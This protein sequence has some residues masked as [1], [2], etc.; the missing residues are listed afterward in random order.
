MEQALEPELE[1]ELQEADPRAQVFKA[2][3]SRLLRDL[4]VTDD[5]YEASLK[6]KEMRRLVEA[7]K[8]PVGEEDAMVLELAEQ[9]AKNSQLLERKLFARELRMESFRAWR[10]ILNTTYAILGIFVGVTTLA[11]TLYLLSISTYNPWLA[12]V[13]IVVSVGITV[14]NF[15]VYRAEKK[16]ERQHQEPRPDVAA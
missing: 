2:Q 13:Q 4:A 3:I 5:T 8:Q 9:K 14:V 11:S 16:P 1:D 15:L 12:A 6:V 7:Y 10:H